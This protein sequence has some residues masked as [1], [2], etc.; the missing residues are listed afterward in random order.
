[1]RIFLTGVTGYVGK[2]LLPVLI[3]KGHHVICCVREKSRLNFHKNLLEK[4]EIIEIDFL[5]E[6]DFDTIQ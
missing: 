4:I 5:E 2:R 6:P 3:E 1:M